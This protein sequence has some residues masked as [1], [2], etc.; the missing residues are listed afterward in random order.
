[1][2]LESTVE[3]LRKLLSFTSIF[4]NVEALKNEFHYWPKVV[5]HNEIHWFPLFQSDDRKLGK[6]S[7]ASRRTMVEKIAIKAVWRSSNFTFK[8]SL[9]LRFDRNHF[10]RK[11]IIVIWKRSF[12]F[13]EQTLFCCC[14]LMLRF[15]GERFAEVIG[16]IQGQTPFTVTVCFR[17]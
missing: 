15:F 6:D 14:T 1:M 8:R 5:I 12:K 13:R 7:L 9:H 17:L 11:V 4:G 16:Q 3:K 10:A 2:R